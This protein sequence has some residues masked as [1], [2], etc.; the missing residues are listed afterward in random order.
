VVLTYSGLAVGPLAFTVTNLS[1]NTA[2]YYRAYASNSVG[3]TLSS[4]TNVVTLG[5]TNM[6]TITA[7]AGVNGSVAPAGGI[8]VAY[9]SSTNFVIT[10]SNYYRIASLTTNGMAVTGM[11]FDNN[12]TTTNFTWSNVQTSGVLTVTFT[13]QVV[14][15]AANTPHEWLAG[16][17]LTNSGATFDQA[18]AADQDGDGLTAWQEYIAGTDPTNTTSGLMAAQ[19]ARNVISWSPVSGRAYSVYWTTNL[20]NG[21]QPLETN[22]LYP[23]GSYTNLNPG[24]RVNL[25]QIKV[26]MQ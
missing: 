8:P 1:P 11:S 16:Y 6:L 17:G 9:G 21:F 10:A 19:S 3:I 26:R 24:P 25:Y 23:Q 5:N 7:T 12:S 2:I 20:M 22:I 18:A 13:A 15:N 4:E 14:T